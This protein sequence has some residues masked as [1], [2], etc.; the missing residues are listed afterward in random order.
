[1]RRTRGYSM[2]EMIVVLMIVA[3]LATAL[4]TGLF[5]LTN[6]A[7]EEAVRG[8]L[9]RIKKGLVG[10]PRVIPP[11]ERDIRRY[12]FMGDLGNLPSRLDSLVNAGS[13]P[14][15]SIDTNLQM[16][17]G[18]R[19]PYEPVLPTDITVDPWGNGIV[20]TVAAGTSTVTG[21]PTVATLTSKGPDGILG[22]A[23]D[24]V[25]EIYRAD[26]FSQ[27]L[28][29]VKDT[30]GVTMPGVGVTLSIPSAGV[31]QNV[32]TTT[33]TSGLYTFNN[34]PQGE[35]VIQLSPKMTYVADTGIVS[36]SS[37][38][39]LTFQLQNL[40]KDAT[41][42]TSMTLTFTSSPVAQ[43]SSVQINGTTV[44]S[45]TGVS[46][47]AIN[48][49]QINVAGTGVI[50]EPIHFFEASGLTMLVPDS[51]IGTVGTGG[52]LTI[53][54]N[55]FN[56]LGTNTNQDMTGVTFSVVCS[57]GSQTLFTAKR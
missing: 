43:Y 34:V 14:D 36:G 23:D 42:I 19:G 7:R 39:N 22:T 17:A 6:N 28:G 55:G 18:W 26:A 44:F 12:G 10:D 40:G 41:S 31:I 49:S 50:Q 38:N 56:Q 48:F 57:D 15:Y 20:Y 37:Y 32:S 25:V 45:G 53:K 8:Q 13:F 54:V 47:T 3:V 11:G 51:V 21:A 29:Y 27:V 9:D 1:M 5:S 2:L 33:D 24:S 16:G 4:G 30:T 52:S 46:G 35:R